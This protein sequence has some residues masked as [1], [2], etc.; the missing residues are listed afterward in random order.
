[1]SG[2][3]T[4]LD[5]TCGSGAFLVEALKRLVY[6]K[7]QGAAPRREV[8]EEVL[9]TQI[10]GVDKS[11]AA[12]RVAA[13]SLYLA[14]M[15]LD[16]GVHLDQLQTFRPL[17][18]RTLLVGDARDIETTTEGAA[19]LATPTGLRKFDL[20]L[21]NPPWTFR[22]K[23]GTKI[24]QKFSAGEMSPR[25]ESLD[26]V[27]RAKGFAHA[28]TR[29]GMILSATPFFSRSAT[30]LGAV[31]TAV[32]GLSPLTLVNLANLS[33][34]LF[35]NASMP[36]LA[37]LARH[38]GGQAGQMTLVQTHWSQAGESSHSI[39]IAP[40]DVTT[41]PIASWERDA[42]LLKAAFVGRRHDL[43]LLDRLSERYEPLESRLKALG[44]QLRVGLQ[45]GRSGQKNAG[46]LSGLPLPL[47]G[48]LG[49][50]SFLL[51]S[52]CF[53]GL[54]PNGPVVERLT[55]RRSC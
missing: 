2:T 1:M 21:G 44:T 27:V 36:A 39:E 12:I 6:L 18:G 11:E 34:W 31:R 23:S 3:E 51:I 26:F 7:S 32:E 15:E 37:M 20:I 46:A 45:T 24:R 16:P 53:P 55:A 4:A 10:Y 19:A 43:L 5:L 40:S 13:F 22:G 35:K 8:I 49:V 38:R 14:A 52:R 54:A 30:G 29:F 41:L 42:R 17:V 25:G 48:Q 47:T 50:S 28:K 9:Y 33:G